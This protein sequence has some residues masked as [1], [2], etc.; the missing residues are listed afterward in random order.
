MTN[1]RP[2]GNQYTDYYYS[3]YNSGAAEQ[4]ER[5]ID[6]FEATADSPETSQKNDD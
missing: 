3:Y 2:T 4:T 6:L 5:N 1:N